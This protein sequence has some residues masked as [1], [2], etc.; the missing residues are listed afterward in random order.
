MKRMLLP[1][2]ASRA[3]SIDFLGGAV[4]EKKYEKDITEDKW[5]IQGTLNDCGR[6]I[7]FSLR[8]VR[9]SAI[10]LIVGGCF[11]FA[12]EVQKLSLAAQG[13]DVTYPVKTFQDGKARFYQ[14]KTGDGI[15]IKY[16]ILKSSDGSSGRPSTPATSAGRRGKATIR[17]MIIW[18]AAIAGGVL[19]R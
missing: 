8:G 5:G 4:T 17:K 1:K 18:S 16:F 12:P 11:L 14:H 10:I 19:L 2:G 9:L 15:T 6:R 13:T 3:D 7:A